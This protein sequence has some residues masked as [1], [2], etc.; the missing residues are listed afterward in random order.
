MVVQR[1]R[2]D[3]LRVCPNRKLKEHCPQRCPETEKQEAPHIPM[4]P[5]HA[6]NVES[7]AGNADA[8]IQSAHQRDK[9][10]QCL[11]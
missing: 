11:A 1:M 9:S 5:A 3:A 10:F 2:M 6:E 8:P 4:F 7:E